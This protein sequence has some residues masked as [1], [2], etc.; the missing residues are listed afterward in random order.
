MFQ[1]IDFFSDTV[2]RPTPGMRKAM[3]E[4]TVG[5]EQ[6]GEDPTTRALEAKVADMVGHSASTFLPSATMANQIALQL[7]CRPGDEILAAESAHVFFA[8]AGGPA[9][10]AGAQSRPIATTSG[11]FEGTQVRKG[12]RPSGPHYP[13]TKLVVVENTANMSGGLAW[14][15]AQ[16]ESVV[17][18]ARELKL[19]S[20]LDGARLFNAAAACGRSVKEIASPFDTVTLCLSKGLG[21]PMGAVLTFPEEKWNDVRRLKQR[22]GGAM[23]QS[24]VLAAAGLYALE[25]NVE[26]LTEDHENARALREGLQLIPAIEVEIQKDFISTNMVFFQWK[27]KEMTAGEFLERSLAQGVRFCPAGENRFRA[28][29]HLD[30]KRSDVERAISLVRNLNA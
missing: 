29:T 17:G 15:T 1:G 27:S 11:I 16:L 12:L 3:S 19:K 24:G 25:H 18:V 9:V 23:R 21:C 22:M 14:P 2:T 28:V 5:D 7:H 20:H 10:H 8:E 13:V 4:A 6:L 26:R 30:I